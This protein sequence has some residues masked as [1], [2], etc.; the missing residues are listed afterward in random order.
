MGQPKNKEKKEEPNG[1]FESEKYN[2]LGKKSLKEAQHWVQPGRK[3]N[4]QT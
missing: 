3:K 2:N 1:S 4:E